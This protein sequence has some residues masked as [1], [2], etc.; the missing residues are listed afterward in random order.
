MRNKILISLLSIF[1]LCGCD[2]PEEYSHPENPKKPGQLEVTPTTTTP[3]GTTSTTTTTTTTTT[4]PA[5]TETAAPAAPATP[6]AE[7]DS[8]KTK[9]GDAAVTQE[10]EALNVDAS[11]EVDVTIGSP[12]KV[13]VESSENSF[14]QI[15]LEVKDNTLN[16]TTRNNFNATV[17]KVH[18]TMPKLTSINAKNSALIKVNGINGGAIAVNAFGACTVELNGTADSIAVNAGEACCVKGKGLQAKT[19]TINTADKC[20]VEVYT[21]EEVAA[22]SRG[23]SVVNIY[24]QPRKVAKNKKDTSYIT[25]SADKI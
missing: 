14:D 16:V 25:I 8:S 9:T 4:A 24:G 12:T 6:V 23:A 10:F 18:V 17:A 3:A 19:G 15:K 7:R 1:A 22:N 2:N 20:A 11:L 13:S 5:G 21:R